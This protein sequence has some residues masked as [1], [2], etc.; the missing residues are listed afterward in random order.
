MYI[1]FV[2]KFNIYSVLPIVDDETENI[3]KKR[4]KVGFYE[5]INEEKPCFLCKSFKKDFC[6]KSY[7]Y[8]IYPINKSINNNNISKYE[9]YINN[10][11]L[12]NKT[13]G[14]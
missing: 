5:D 10:I 8:K 6:R 7:K 9:N 2:K 13:N 1:M 14:K 11:L 3:Y 4:P 12:Y